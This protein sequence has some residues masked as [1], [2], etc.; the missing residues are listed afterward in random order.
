ML[1]DRRILTILAIIFVQILGASMVLPVLPLFARREF[2]LDP[3][4]ITVLV[5]SFFAAQFLAGPTIGRLS[6]LYGRVPVLVV[7]QI[8]TVI[9][10]L[11]IV[12]AQSVP[13]L[14]VA[15]VLDGITGG[16]IIVAQ[17]YITDI[18][19]KEDRTQALG[20]TFAV[21]GLGFIIGPAS[22]GI[23]SAAL[24]PRAPFLFAALAAAIVVLITWRTLDETLSA[25]QRARN[26]GAGA[27]RGAETGAESAEL[28]LSLRGVAS[29]GPL[30]VILLVSF[31]GQ[32]GLGLVQ[33][34]FALYAEV[35]IFDGYA[36][37]ATDLGIGLLL[38]AVGVGQVVTQVLLL[39]RFRT[40]F[41]DARLVNI[42]VGL[43]G[44]AMAGWSLVRSPWLAVVPSFGFA[45][46]S[47]LLRPPL[48]SLATQT[49]PDEVR[50]TVLGWFQSSI[51]LSTIF[52]TAIGGTLYN[53]GPTV[54]FVLGA[55]MFFAMI[56]PGLLIQRWALRENIEQFPVTRPAAA[57]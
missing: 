35:R 15:R 22:G 16:N 53:I 1:Q 46:G 38:A 4:V 42:G 23:I 34:T 31:G 13:M 40:W 45:I 47:G 18:S 2:E 20:Y 5:S 8:G 33:A 27:V 50:G 51:S 52:A 17:A 10:F 28:G 14:F 36:Q 30:V 55:V 54:P 7:S 3:A 25:E 24:G 32:F 21:F 6:D 49:V 11:M 26:R 19:S 44:V 48:Q 29:N 43:R 39:R 57:D 12:G 37:S 56:L 41:G 9:S